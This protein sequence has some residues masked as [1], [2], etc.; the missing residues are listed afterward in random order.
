[1]IGGYFYL[2][3]KALVCFFSLSKDAFISFIE[4]L[5]SEILDNIELTSKLHFSEDSLIE[6]ILAP[7]S[8]LTD[9]D[10]LTELTEFLI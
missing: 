6:C 5:K 10:E 9:V 2:F 1:M 4:V 3:N 7:I 8:V